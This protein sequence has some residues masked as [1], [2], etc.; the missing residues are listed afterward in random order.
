MYGGGGGGGG[1]GGGEDFGGGGGGG[2]G[3]FGGGGGGGGLRG[4]MHDQ[5]VEGK[6]FLGGLDPSSTNDTVRNYCSQW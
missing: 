1:E 5:L 2:R 4:G 3:G 6:L